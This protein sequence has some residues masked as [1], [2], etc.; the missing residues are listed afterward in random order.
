MEF[1]LM[2]LAV[3][4]EKIGAF[5]SNGFFVAFIGAAIYMAILVGSSMES[6]EGRET[7][8]E[9]MKHPIQKSLVRLGKV[10]VVLGLIAG[11]IGAVL[12][13][14]EELAYIVGGG[15]TYNIVTSDTS[16]RLGSKVLDILE[17]KI[18]G[19]SQDTTKPEPKP[20]PAPSKPEPTPV[21]GQAT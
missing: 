7:T 6:C 10:L 12:P 3:S 13:S 20:D 1:F 19:M 2:Y 15:V 5:L 17:Q 8:A 11:S 18:D 16:K 14:K 4:I 9:I 21:P